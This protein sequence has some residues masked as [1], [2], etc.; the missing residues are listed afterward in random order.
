MCVCM[1]VCMYVCMNP[2]QPPQPTTYLYVYIHIL[3]IFLVGLDGCAV[4][5][6]AS[7]A[8]AEGGSPGGGSADDTRRGDQVCKDQP[9]QRRRLRNCAHQRTGVL[10]GPEPAPY[11][12]KL[13][14]F[15]PKHFF[16]TVF[17]AYTRSATSL[18]PKTYTLNPKP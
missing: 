12:T 3:C 2:P 17:D 4:V 1:Y 8:V 6:C 13:F 18:N 15:L 9:E 14:L 5:C 10:S 7:E 16:M 11:L